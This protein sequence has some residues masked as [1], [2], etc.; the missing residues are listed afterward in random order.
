MS[1]FLCG[2]D[3]SL[4]G[5]ADD[6]QNLSRFLRWLENDFIRLQQEYSHIRLQFNAENSEVMLFNLKSDACWRFKTC[7]IIIELADDIVYLS[8][9]Y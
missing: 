3:L 4:I 7:D 6:L 1:Y 2:I 9:S 8:I 5:Y